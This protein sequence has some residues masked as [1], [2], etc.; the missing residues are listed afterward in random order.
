VPTHDKT[1]SFN[2]PRW[3]QAPVQGGRPP[4]AFQEVWYLKLNDPTQN[5]ALWLRLTL[6]VSANGFKRVA[7]TWAIQ[8]QRTSNKE[9]SKVAL[10]QTFDLGTF[11]CDESGTL[12]AENFELSPTHTR[13]KIIS[14]GHTIE[15]DLQIQQ[16]HEATF[17][18]VPETLSR[19]R[20]VRNTAFTVGEDLRFTGSST[21]DGERT[22][23]KDAAGMQAHLSG[24]KNGHSWV[25]GQCNLFVDAQGK[26]VP[27]LFEGL[28]AKARLGGGL[29]TPRLSTFYFHYEG[30]P[31][32]FN[33]LWDAVR[34]KSRSSLTD[35]HF[36]ADRGDLSFRGT[37][38]AELK[39]FAGLTYEDTNGSL[40]YCANSKLSN[41]EIHVYRRGK[42]ETT[43]YSHG[44]AAFEVV[45]REKNPY[46]P[47]L[48]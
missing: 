13:G 23:W 4:G 26:P 32:E 34:V 6:L 8:F 12:R 17:N 19:S 18:L 21:V 31:Y 10:K 46:V 35:W 11:S 38:Q 41:L 5:R 28:S 16:G 9:V 1:A 22:E 45:T 3:N 43:V 33:T 25:W 40:L 47:I 36:Q 15:W 2:R 42:L 39:E 30:Q 27:F 14:K 44:T 29:S 37:A 20:I 48:V 24:P 7:E